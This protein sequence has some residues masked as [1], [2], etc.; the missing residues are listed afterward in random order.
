MEYGG[1]GGGGGGGGLENWILTSCQPHRVISGVSPE[2]PD[3]G[4]TSD[5]AGLPSVEAGGGGGGG[6]EKRLQTHDYSITGVSTVD[7]S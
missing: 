4:K 3:R 2:I 6:G 5:I 1:G 7:H